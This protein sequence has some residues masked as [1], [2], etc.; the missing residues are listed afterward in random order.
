MVIL[1]GLIYAIIKIKTSWY[2]S[3][4]SW[5][6]LTFNLTYD[7]NKVG[8]R[9]IMRERKQPRVVYTK[10]EKKEEATQKWGESCSNERKGLNIPEKGEFKQARIKTRRS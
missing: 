7:S 6:L 2:Y 4:K 9:E 1:S 5:L 10:R 3:K 8:A